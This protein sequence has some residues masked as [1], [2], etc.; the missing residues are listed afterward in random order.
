M[1]VRAQCL[2]FVFSLILFGFFSFLLTCIIF[3]QRLKLFYFIFYLTE[4]HRLAE[5]FKLFANSFLVGS[6]KIDICRF[7]LFFLII[8][9]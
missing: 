7:I 6:L 9:L 3:S 1:F 5:I 4:V 2:N 8:A